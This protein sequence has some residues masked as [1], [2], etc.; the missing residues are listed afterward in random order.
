MLLKEHIISMS[1]AEGYQIINI[2]EDDGVSAYHKSVNQRQAMIKAKELILSDG[3]DIQALFFY[4][5]S[6]MTRQF[7]D[8]TLSFVNP[9]KA[10]K[11]H[12]KFFSTQTNSEWSPMDINAVL[13]QATAARESVIKSARSIDGQDNSI[14]SRKRPGSEVPFGYKPVRNPIDDT[15]TSSSQIIDEEQAPIVLFIF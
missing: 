4:D 10:A 3:E 9:I 2:F 8:F 11:P 12:F 5:E 7:F 13:N 1:N 14:K 6:R 15:R